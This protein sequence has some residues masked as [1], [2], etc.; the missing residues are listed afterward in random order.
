VV[1]PTGATAFPLQKDTVLKAESECGDPKLTV[2]VTSCGAAYKGAAKCMVDVE[3]GHSLCAALERPYEGTTKGRGVTAVSGYWDM[4]GEWKQ[5]PRVVTLSCNASAGLDQTLSADGAI[6][7]CIQNW[8]YDPETHQDQFLACIRAVRADYCGDG[9]AHTQYATDLDIH[10]TATNV[11]TRDQCND[12]RA[13]EA[14]WSKSGAVCLA[15][16]RWRDVNQCKPKFGP[17]ATSPS[18]SCRTDA[19]PAILRTRSRGHACTNASRSDF[20]LPDTEPVCNPGATP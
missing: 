2:K 6:T 19:G 17:T 5:D 20:A 3:S 4:S 9:T 18:E 13:F 10:G 1:N 12:G 11:M 7:T 15:H 14:S 16:E 8:R